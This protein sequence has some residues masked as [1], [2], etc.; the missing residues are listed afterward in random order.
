MEEMPDNQGDTSDPGHDFDSSTG[1]QDSGS[2]MIPKY[3]D[4]DSE[5]LTQSG[6]SQ[7]P[8][9]SEAVIEA[10]AGPSGMQGVS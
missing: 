7:A 1:G 2:L 6:L 5:G 10:L 9:L 8:P 3:D 4:Q